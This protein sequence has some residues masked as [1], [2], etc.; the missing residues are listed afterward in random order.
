MVYPT[1]HANPWTPTG[2]NNPAANPL[3]WGSTAASGRASAYERSLVGIATTK[4]IRVAVVD[5]AGEAVANLTGAFMDGQVT[6]DARGDVSRSGS[7]TVL[8]AGRRFGFDADTYSG[9]D[10]DLTRMIR[11]WWVTDSDILEDSVTCPIFTGP[12][13]RLARSGPVVTIEAQSKEV[14]GLARGGRTLT[15]KKG[16]RK[17]D[18]IRTILRERMGE[19][20]M[21]IPDLPAKLSA[22]VVIRPRDQAWKVAQKIAQ[23]MGKQLL[24]TADGVARLRE[25]PDKP[26]WAF[27][28]EGALASLITEP[29]TEADL[30]EVVNQVKV[31]GRT[32]KGKKQPVSGVAT[33]EPSHPLSPWKLGPPG[34]PM[35]MLKEVSNDHC[36]TDAECLKLAKQ[37][38]ER[39][40][41]LGRDV[42]F[43]AVPIPFLE[44]LDKV[45]V[46]TPFES[47][48]CRV[49]TLT[50]P[51]GL[52]GNMQ[53]GYSG[54]YHLRKSRG[55]RKH[56]GNAHANPLRRS[57]QRQA[58]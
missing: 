45:I 9:S 11:A 13:T 20:R 47:L 55:K 29:E 54:P 17:T 28:A 5:R 15:I 38:L 31:T 10:L 27:T 8:D 58:A 41:K 7:F 49:E 24:Y 14:Y 53:F 50:L 21:A 4:R 57:F 25:L 6:L 30:T 26:A 19:T 39:G 40:L 3:Q 36:R 46:R 2:G 35:F 52:T 12:I 1:I 18:A 51:L 42:A 56:R 16:A 32:P 22:N 43:D 33:A 34:G 44:P 48:D 23:S 37:H